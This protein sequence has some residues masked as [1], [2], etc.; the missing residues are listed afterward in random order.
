MRSR[1]GQNRCMA[2]AEQINVEVIYALP[3]Q[4]HRVALKVT[5]GTTL[6]RAIQESGLLQRC[7]EIDLTMNKVG[8]FGRLRDLDALLK[9][10]DRVEIYRPLRADPKEARRQRVEDKRKNEQ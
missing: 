4:V 8:I 5:A 7:P 6:M 2:G 9:E 3:E 1:A 10:G